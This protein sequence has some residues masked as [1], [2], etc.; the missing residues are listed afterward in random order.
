MHYL[1]WYL[2]ILIIILWLMHLWDVSFII[3]DDKFSDAG[4]DNKSYKIKIGLID[5]VIAFSRC[6]FFSLIIFELVCSKFQ[7][8]KN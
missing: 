3:I 7:L 1:I 2:S 8:K 6:A 5:F 4:Y